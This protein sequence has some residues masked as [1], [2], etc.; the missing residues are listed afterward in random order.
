MKIYKNGKVFLL[1]Y[2]WLLTC[3]TAFIINTS[4]HC[5][6]TGFNYLNITVQYSTNQYSNLQKVISILTI[7]KTIKY[8]KLLKKI[9]NIYGI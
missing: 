5:L 9:S 1:N 7:N 8:M 2:L 3:C 6:I 4:R